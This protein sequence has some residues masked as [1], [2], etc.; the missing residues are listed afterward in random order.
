MIAV[1]ALI[2]TLIAAQTTPLVAPTARAQPPATILAEPAAL[3]IAG[4][5]ADGDARVTRAELTA[6]IA[7][8]H[9]TADGAA[10]G[11]VGYIA[12][13]DWAQRWLGDRNAL[14]GPYEVDTNGD[15]RIALPELQAAFA[16]YFIRYDIDKDGIVTR[17]ELV[18]LRSAPPMLDD[19]KRGRKR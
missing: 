12:F 18:T 2:A 14:P 3:F 19:G 10:A 7:K 13:A 9:A 6:C 8:A 15:N 17:A 11:T 1:P 16:R 5:D 4:C